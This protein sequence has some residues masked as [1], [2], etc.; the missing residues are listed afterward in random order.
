MRRAAPRGEGASR[1]VFLMTAMAARREGPIPAE[2]SR[3]GPRQSALGAAA[4]RDPRRL[5]PRHPHAPMCPH[6]VQNSQPSLRITVALPHSGQ[7]V[8]GSGFA[9]VA[10]AGACRMPIACSG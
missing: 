10:A 7:R 3:A 2:S 1:S 9:S 6:A 4:S 8:P 5:L